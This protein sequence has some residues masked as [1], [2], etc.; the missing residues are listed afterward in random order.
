MKKFLYK[1]YKNYFKFCFTGF[2]LHFFT[3]KWNFFFVLDRDVTF[4]IENIEFD[5]L[6]VNVFQCTVMTWL[7]HNGSNVEYSSTV[8][9]KFGFF[10]NYT[11]V[12]LSKHRYISRTAFIFWLLLI[13]VT[14]CLIVIITNPKIRNTIF[15]PTNIDFFH[16]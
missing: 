6:N 15:F 8:F 12:L 11:M 4:C 9:K 3:F 7:Y 2:L 5:V 13:T 1:D 10:D 14:L 16:K